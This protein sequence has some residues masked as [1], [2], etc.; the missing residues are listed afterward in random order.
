[1]IKINRLPADAA[2][3]LIKFIGSKWIEGV[4]MFYN[5]YEELY[6]IEIDNS[7][8]V[9]MKHWSSDSEPCVFLHLGEN[10]MQVTLNGSEVTIN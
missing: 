1:M 8:P 4:K 5:E 2:N 3:S 9:F 7:V 10:I 6:E